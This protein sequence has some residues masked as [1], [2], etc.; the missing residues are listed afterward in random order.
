M[1]IWRPFI[2]QKKKEK[3]PPFLLGRLGY[4]YFIIYF[5]RSVIF[6]CCCLSSIGIVILG[7]TDGKQK[8]G[9]GSISSLEKCGHKLMRREIG[10]LPQKGA[11]KRQIS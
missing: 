4:K 3:C 8:E 6:F 10:A 1:N 11:L 9:Q 5:K 7:R 2:K